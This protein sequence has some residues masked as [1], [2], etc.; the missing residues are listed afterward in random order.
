MRSDA[1]EHYPELAAKLEYANG[2][3]VIIWAPRGTA[4]TRATDAATPSRGDGEPLITDGDK[5]AGLS[6]RGPGVEREP[7]PVALQRRLRLTSRSERARNVRVLTPERGFRVRS[8][9]T[10]IAQRLQFET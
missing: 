7:Q 1:A 9:W 8:E 4:S 2:L 5:M 3:P 10:C 6:R